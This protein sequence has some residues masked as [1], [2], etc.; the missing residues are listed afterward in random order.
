[1]RRDR[2]G[3]PI[4]LHASRFCVPADACELDDISDAFELVSMV[5]SANTSR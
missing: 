5:A 4:G 1:M 3:I 2:G